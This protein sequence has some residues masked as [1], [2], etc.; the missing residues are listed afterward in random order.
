M[1]K[2]VYVLLIM[3]T[4]V[5]AI[6]FAA[7]NYDLVTLDYLFGETELPLS[8][9]IIVSFLSGLVIG[10]LMDAWILYRQRARIH[11]LQKLVEANQK[12]LDNLRSLPLRDLEQ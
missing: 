9:L 8:I 1:I 11:G 6:V 2:T 4:L 3:A 7:A 10:V 5:V 12:E